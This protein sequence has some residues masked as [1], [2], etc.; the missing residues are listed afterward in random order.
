M[1]TIKLKNVNLVVDTPQTFLTSDTAAS[2][3]TLTV[4]NISGFAINQVLIIGDLGNQGTE[5][6]KT[7]ASTAPTG[8]TITLASATVFPHSSST[9]IRVLQYDEAEFSTATTIAGAKTVLT[10]TNIWA[11]NDSTNYIDNSGATGYYFGRFYNSITS[12]FSSYSSPIPVAGYGVLS[13]RAVIDSALKGI[14]KK[15]SE[16]LSDSFAFGELDNFQTEVLRELKR[17][18]FM[19]KFNSIIG[20]ATTGS[21]KIAVPTDLDDQNTNKSVY[22]LRLGTNARLDWVDKEKF[23]ELLG[24]MAFTTIA[25][26]LNVGDATMTL[27]NSGDFE[28]SGTVTIGAYTYSYTANNTQTG[29]LT[30]SVVV[31]TGQGQSVGADVFLNPQSGLPNYWTTFGGYIYWLPITASEYNGNNMYLDYYIAQTRITSDSQNLIVPDPT[32]AIYYLQSKFI[33]ALNNGQTTPDSQEYDAKYV[34]RV[35]KMKQ[36]EVLGKTFKLRPRINNYSTQSRF[37]NNDSRITRTG[38]FTNTGF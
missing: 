4:K 3:S 28:A 34:D 8:S 7:H 27:T 12:T 17:W 5:I 20:Q 24:D 32:A 18:S 9:V 14:N 6:I 16:V 2:S 23:D 11:D 22:N 1:A 13:A 29:V 15:T 31:P 19:Q 10:T 38:N 37:D 21:W 26:T 35:K 30:L 36:K 25:S 33:K